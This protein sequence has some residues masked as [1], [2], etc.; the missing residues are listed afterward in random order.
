MITRWQG[1]ERAS[2]SDSFSSAEDFSAFPGLGW[3]LLGWWLTAPCNGEDGVHSSGGFGD[4][5]YNDDVVNVID[6]GDVGDYNG[7]F[8]A[9]DYNDDVGD[10][11]YND[12]GN[13]G[14]YYHIVELGKEVGEHREHVLLVEADR[15]LGSSQP[16]EI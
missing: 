9:D 1:E 2:F 13:V 5:D 4:D 7:D 10:D 11:D 15:S 12:D 3:R 14:D 8:G 6:V 16:G